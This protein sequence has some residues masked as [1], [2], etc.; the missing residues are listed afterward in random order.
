MSTRS[1][2]SSTTGRADASRSVRCVRRRPPPGL[3]ALAGGQVAAHATPAR[4]ARAAGEWPIDG[5]D[6]VVLAPQ[7]RDHPQ[8]HPP[9]LT[10]SWCTL[11]N[12]GTG[13]SKAPRPHLKE[14]LR[15]NPTGGGALPEDRE[16]PGEAAG[17]MREFPLCGTSSVATA[18]TTHP[19]AIR[20]PTT[21]VDANELVCSTS[22][23]PSISCEIEQ[24]LVLLVLFLDGL[25][26]LVGDGPPLRIGP[27]LADQRRSRGRSPRSRRLSQ[28]SDPR[29]AGTR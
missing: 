3:A 21:A 29:I 9:R 22:L 4:C 25:P 8:P 10:R 2:P 13:R 7:S 1:T 18:A 19:H 24:F 5:P 6:R 26:L 20:E 17:G 27:V 12:R 11:A 28:P 14:R 16:R 15:P 23:R